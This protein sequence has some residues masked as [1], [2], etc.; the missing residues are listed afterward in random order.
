[1]IYSRRHT[2]RQSALAYIQVDKLVGLMRSSLAASNL[3]ATTFTIRSCP[4]ISYADI[5]KELA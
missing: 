1:M 3:Q 2:K 5:K 4:V